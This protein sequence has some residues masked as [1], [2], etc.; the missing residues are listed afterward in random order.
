MKR[1]A[2][3]RPKDRQEESLELA[4]SMGFEAIGASPIDLKV[5][6]SEAF[7]IFL[8]DLV[9][10]RVG[11]IILTSSAGVRAL[12]DLADRRARKRELLARLEGVRVVA[13]GPVTARQAER[14]M[15]RVDG[16]PEEFTSEGLVRALSS[17]YSSDKLA[18]VLRSDHGSPLLLAGLQGAG[19]SVK[20]VVVYTLTKRSDAPDV[21]SMVQLG[22]AGGVDVFVFTSSLSAMTLLEAWASETSLLD[23]VA[24]LNLRA[25]AA[26]GPPTRETLESY[27]VRVGI[28]PEKATF[29][30]LLAAI[31]RRLGAE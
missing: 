6:D 3:M 17:S 22:I 21:K 28:M 27:G 18:Y 12:L 15:M 19:Y 29:A 20:E 2:I 11:M 23:A 5:R 25:V 4:R 30:K 1:L 26:I 7:E 14:N 24:K 16:M 31:R 10:G 8:D 13:I 9:N